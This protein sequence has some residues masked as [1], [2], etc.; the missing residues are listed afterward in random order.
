M[1]RFCFID[2]A[3]LA[4]IAR[5]DNE[6]MENTTVPDVE[7]NETYRGQKWKVFYCFWPLTGELL[8]T[9]LP[10]EIG[11][12]DTREICGQMTTEN[13][14]CLRQFG[15]NGKFPVFG[16]S[17][18]F[19]LFTKEKKTY[20]CWKCITIILQWRGDNNSSQ[21]FFRNI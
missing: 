20:F 5:D 21:K 7:P 8:A 1:F 3:Y 19:V 10:T 18:H 11:I 16:K 4:T 14:R 13:N 15:K 9:S 17:F 2:I 12:L 6:S